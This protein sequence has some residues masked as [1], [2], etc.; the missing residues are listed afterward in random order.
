MR[1]LFATDHIHYPQGGGGAER[2]THELCL[3]LKNQSI[4][5]AV[6]CSLAPRTSW[7]SL[8]NRIKR[9]LHP[10]LHFP[11]DSFCGYPVYRGWDNDIS[12]VI[13]AFRPNVGVVQS[14]KPTQLLST[15]SECNI[16]A[17]CYI[18]EVE[19]IA[20]LKTHAGT[21]HFLANSHFTALRLSE[22]CG[23]KASVIFPLIQPTYYKT[24]CNPSSVLFVNTV[25]RKGLEIAFNLAE[26]RPDISFDFVQSWILR[27]NEIASLVKRA[28][29]CGNITLH[30]PTSNMKKLYARAKLLLVPSL[31]EEAWGRVVTEA[32]INGIPV[33][34][35]NQGGLPESV[36]PGGILLPITSSTARW[37]E[38]LSTLYDND[39]VYLS[40]SASALAYS[41]REAI[42]PSVI[43]SALLTALTTPT[44][45]LPNAG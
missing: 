20:H 16:P 27:P 40:Y 44:M 24:E 8:T 10:R 13:H 33:L 5:V 32:H 38:A 19:D 6:V 43:A 12:E 39:S 2:N 29:A 15:F 28:S 23:I 21:V 41:D 25:Q 14:T 22:L 9:K 34:A 36:G 7:L 11:K 45:R 35:S 3:Q 17:A 4:N 26:N 18:H 42:K 37:L 31:W 30:K 1:I